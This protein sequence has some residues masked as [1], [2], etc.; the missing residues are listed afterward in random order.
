[1]QSLCF[2]LERSG[3]WI[4]PE[5]PPYDGRSTIGTP[6]GYIPHMSSESL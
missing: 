5:L 3:L 6:L 2:M 4:G 1:V